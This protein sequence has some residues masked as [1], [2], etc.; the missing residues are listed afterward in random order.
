MVAP[1][2]SILHFRSSDIAK[3]LT[4][5]EFEIYESIRPRECL[6][7]AWNKENR[8]TKAPNIYAMIRFTNSVVSTIINEILC[9]ENVKDRAK[10]VKKFI[11]VADVCKQ[12]GNYN[13]ILEVIAGLHSTA[14]SRLKK[15]WELVPQEYVKLLDSLEATMS[16]GSSYKML[17]EELRTQNPPA[18]PCLP[19]FLT[20]LTFIE[21]GNPDLVQSKINFNKRRKLSL[22][23]R[24]IQRWQKIP[25]DF[26]GIPEVRRKFSQ[27]N[28]VTDELVLYKL[29]L[30]R[31]PK[32]L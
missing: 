2:T 27:T 11:K 28:L 13:A 12:I 26:A 15:T 7:Q 1:D 19:V 32:K 17:R 14:I 10:L 23:I 21:D 4:M 29:S 31:E 18:I 20:D 6:N 30:E 24:Q 8:Q 16:Q 25:F 3:Q 9:L 22:V 5:M